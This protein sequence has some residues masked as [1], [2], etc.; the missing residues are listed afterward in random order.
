MKLFEYFLDA[1]YLGIPIYKYFHNDMAGMKKVKVK[2]NIIQNGKR[3]SLF[4]FFY[5]LY[6]HSPVKSCLNLAIEVWPTASEPR[7]NWSYFSN[8]NDTD[9]SFYVT[10]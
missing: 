4:L 6:I 2:T 3:V 1:L 8:M 7:G 9:L 5:D 10:D